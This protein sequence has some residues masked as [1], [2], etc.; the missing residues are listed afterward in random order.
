MDS[1]SVNSNSSNKPVILYKK[2]PLFLAKSLEK[3]VF[4]NSVRYPTK[5]Y[6]FTN[7]TDIF[8]SKRYYTD[9]L[10]PKAIRA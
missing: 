3:E 2:K 7:F 9:Y 1:F 5:L 4:K 6:S 8:N 10:I